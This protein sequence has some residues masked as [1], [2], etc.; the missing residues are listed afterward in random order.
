MIVFFLTKREELVEKVVNVPMSMDGR[1]L[2]AEITSFE[3]LNTCEKGINIGN[4]ALMRIVDDCLIP[5][6]PIGNM[7]KTMCRQSMD[8][9]RRTT[10]RQF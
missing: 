8:F 9:G 1:G 6:M 4:H 10:D 5:W 3:Q 7:A 2:A